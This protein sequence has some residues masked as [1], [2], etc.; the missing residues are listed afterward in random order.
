MA[1]K[2]RRG[3]FATDICHA[4]S[5]VFPRPPAVVENLPFVKR[6]APNNPHYRISGAQRDNKSVL[7]VQVFTVLA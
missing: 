3:H 5:P 7:S 2:S 1:I 6:E 4:Q